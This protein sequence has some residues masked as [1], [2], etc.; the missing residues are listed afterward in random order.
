MIFSQSPVIFIACILGLALFAILVWF[1]FYLVRHRPYLAKPVDA[2]QALDCMPRPARGEVLPEY[3]RQNHP[4]VYCDDDLACPPPSYQAVFTRHS[5][6]TPDEL[7]VLHRRLEKLQR[8][9]RRRSGGG[10]TTAGET[11]I[12]DSEIRCLAQW[13]ERLEMLRDEEEQ[14]AGPA[15]PGRRRTVRLVQS[16]S[17]PAMLLSRSATVRGSSA[18]AAQQGSTLGRSATEPG[19]VCFAPSREVAPPPTPMAAPTSPTAAE[20][21][22]QLAELREQLMRVLPSGPST[23]R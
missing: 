12:R 14:D 10:D 4:P 8:R 17:E 7:R 21:D 22:L 11:A 16:E 13:I 5:A 15:L 20:M 6:P 3:S 18:A 9:R 19:L 2:E 1:G 23:E